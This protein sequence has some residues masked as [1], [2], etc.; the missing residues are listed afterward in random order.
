MDMH[1]PA[2]PGE[3]LREDYL[4]YLNMG[5]TDLA[6]A[7]GISR[8][9]L[10]RVLHEHAGISPN[11]AVRLEIAGFGS[12]RMWLAMQV[13]RDLWIEK[14]KPHENVQRQLLPA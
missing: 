14:Q 4:P 8:P 5:V 1:N 10:S 13:K 11:L 3:I 12:A 9:N 7:L 2:H 6:D